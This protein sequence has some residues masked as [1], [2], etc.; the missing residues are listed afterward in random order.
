MSAK[1]PTTESLGLA[2]P[3]G[4]SYVSVKLALVAQRSAK[5]GAGLDVSST[6]ASR[7]GITLRRYIA[8]A[9]ATENRAT[10]RNQQRPEIEDVTYKDTTSPDECSQ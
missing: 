10:A 6:A 2:E 5:E 9:Q 8:T 7:A 3:R 1:K 4:N